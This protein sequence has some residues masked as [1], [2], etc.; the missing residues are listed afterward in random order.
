M[1][2]SGMHIYKRN[3]Y[4]RICIYLVCTYIRGTGMNGYDFAVLYNFAVLYDLAA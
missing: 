1:Y 3:W 2:L 4:E